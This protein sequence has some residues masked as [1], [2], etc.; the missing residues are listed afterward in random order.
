MR[1]RMFAAT[2][3]AWP[4][5]LAA[6]STTPEGAYL[7]YGEP[8]GVSFIIATA[9]PWARRPCSDRPIAKR[10]ASPAR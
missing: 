9:R 2:L 6:Q 10:A 8:G 1:V 4:A 7:I 5:A 3:L